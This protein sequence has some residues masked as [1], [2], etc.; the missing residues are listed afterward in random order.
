MLSRTHPLR[1]EL[2]R[3]L[4]ERPFAVEL[5]DGTSVPATNGGGGPTFRVRSPR[6]LAHLLRAPGE[7]GLGRA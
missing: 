4:P 5:W 3:A 2:E 1:R 7:L 6:A